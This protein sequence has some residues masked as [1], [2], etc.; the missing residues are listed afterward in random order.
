M[1][2]PSVTAVGDIALPFENV[3]LKHL[4]TA[5]GA[6]VVVR[7]EPRSQL[8]IY[9][10]MKKLP[11]EVPPNADLDHAMQDQ[12]FATD[13]LKQSMA[14]AEHVIEMTTSFVDGDGNTV[15]PA[16]WFHP[17]AKH[18]L[19][20]DGRYLHD[21]DRLLLLRSAL[22]QT[23]YLT[24]EEDKSTDASFPA[25]DAGGAADGVG[26]VGHGGGAGAPPV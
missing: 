8:A 25:G 15:S 26:D 14:A 6:P 19:S 18:A 4:K 22:R 9:E 12:S 10:V 2:N 3:T 5:V 21:E 23:G 13:L 17:E 20:I 16:F 7:V 24:G 11:G 1:E